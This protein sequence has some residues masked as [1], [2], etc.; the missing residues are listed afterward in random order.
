ME[1]NYKKNDLPINGFLLPLQNIRHL[2]P[3]C[4]KYA[5]YI[6]QIEIDSL[7]RGRKH[8]VWQLDR[9]INVLSGVNGV[10]KSTIL[11]KVVT[12]LLMAHGRVDNENGVQLQLHEADAEAIRFDI[13]RSF[14]RPLISSDITARLDFKIATELDLQLFNL[15]RRYLDYQVNLG[16]R[17]IEMLQSGKPDAPQLAQRLSESKKQFHDI[18]DKLFEDTKKSIIRT[19]NE[20]R[21]HQMG[22]VL[23]PYQLSSG[24][25]QMLVILLT[26]LVEDQQ[27]YVL[28]MDEPEVSL[29]IEWQKQLLSIIMQLNPNVQ[30]ILTTHSPAVIMDGW[31]DKV[32]EVNEIEVK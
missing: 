11:N 13:V 7:W 16:N 19:E 30:V 14:D 8:I 27:P 20:I 4:M 26:V 5:E 15:Q 10:G 32:T 22:E 24:E 17:I 1:L 2:T 29:H 21:F 25:K 23:M 31:T 3:Q 9:H 6:K 12:P 28:F 18:V